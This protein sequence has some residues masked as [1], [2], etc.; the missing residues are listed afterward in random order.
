MKFFIWKWKNNMV[1]TVET[2]A[3]G[4]VIVL[5]VIGA[6]AHADFGPKLVQMIRIDV[7]LEGEPVSNKATGV[8]LAPASEGGFAPLNAAKEASGLDIPYKDETGR[9][10]NYAAYLWG[11]KFENGTVNFK[12]FEYDNG[13]MPSRVRLAVYDSESE[14][15]YVTEIARPGALLCLMQAD[16]DSDGTGTLKVLAIPFWRRFDF[17]KALLITIVV[18]CLIVGRIGHQVRQSKQQ[19]QENR[20]SSL[21]KLIILCV[22]VNI[23]T[24]P[25]VWFFGGHYLFTLG[26]TWGIAAFL[27]FEVAAFLI[28][29]TTYWRSGKL[30]PV[31]AYQ[32]AFIANG[33]SFALGFVL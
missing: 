32:A 19:H 8:L 11:G 10:W 6:E 4:F 21:G 29:G 28:E 20:K 26:R 13:G 31:R 17:W 7:R 25:L 9:N 16:L 18:E 3:I 23:F 15:L 2:R 14:K 5:I 33:V 30:S 22:L 27:G 12:G 24:L 1:R